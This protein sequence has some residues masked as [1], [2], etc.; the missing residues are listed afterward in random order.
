[1]KNI[2]IVGGGFAGLWAAMSAAAERDH[3]GISPQELNIHLINKDGFLVVRPRLYEGAQDSM[4][5][6]LRPLLDAIDVG[7]SEALVSD[8][9]PL[10]NEITFDKSDAVHVHKFDELILASGSQIRALPIEGARQFGFCNDTFD[11]AAKLDKHLGS[12][13][14]LPVVVVGA[15]FTGIE[16]ATELRSRLGED[17]RIILIDQQA[18]VGQELGSNLT[19]KISSALLECEIE[20]RL[21]A[22]ITKMDKNSLTLKSGETIATETVIFAT[23]QEASPLTRFFDGQ[24]DNLGRL[25]VDPNLKLPEYD[26]IFIAGDTAHAMADENHATLMSCQHAMQLGRFAGYNA[27]RDIA[28]KPLQAYSQEVYRTCL[29]LG[30]AGAV[31]TMGWDRQIQKSGPECK[32]VKLQITQELIYPPTPEAGAQPIFEAIGLSH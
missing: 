18:K 16:T 26:D 1:M 23:G 25:I 10:K 29:D 8:I 12:G 2:T 28:G 4:K 9:D 5:V 24:K 15:G 13:T 32:A 17:T 19:P 6:P 20:T 14:R 7:F 11:D 22:S 3:W 31:L 27:V 30:P 21:N